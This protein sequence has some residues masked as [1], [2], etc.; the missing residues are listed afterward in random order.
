MFYT[1]GVLTDCFD[2]AYTWQISDDT[3][4][5]KSHCQQGI[6]SDHGACWYGFVAWKQWSKKDET[7]FQF[8]VVFTFTFDKIDQFSNGCRNKGIHDNWFFLQQVAGFMRKALRQVNTAIVRRF[9]YTVTL[10]VTSLTRKLEHRTQVEWNPGNE[11]SQIRRNI[12][13][14]NVPSISALNHKSHRQFIPETGWIWLKGKRHN[15]L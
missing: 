14:Q 3:P 2:V 6:N 10:K 5:L 13:V 8:H 9:L 7:S 1:N 4:K 12:D 11:N 15:V